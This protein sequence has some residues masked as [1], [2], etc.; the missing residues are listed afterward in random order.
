MRH[1]GLIQTLA[2]GA[3]LSIAACSSPLQGAEGR[4]SKGSGNTAAASKNLPEGQATAVFAMGCFWC[5]EAD[6]EKIDGVVDVVSG[7]TGGSTKNPT[8]QQVTYANT[9]HYEAVLVTYDTAKL[10][11]A[12]LLP[13][14]W[15]NVDPF[16]PNGQFC[17]KG[18]SY[19]S[20]IFPANVQ[21]SNLAKASKK[22]WEGVFN[23][24]IA[25]AIIDRAK[26]YKAEKY[27]QDYYK[28]NPIRYKFYRSRCGRDDRL[29]DVWGSK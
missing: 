26:F 20:A 24:D 6:F 11:Y 13:V 14:F 9:G 16:D 10:S 2:L 21:E 17:D 22:R 23:A 15:K 18:S 7:Y 28:K 27:H 8:Y 29:E 3:C 1:F 5:A 12:D 25:T 4:T 19:R